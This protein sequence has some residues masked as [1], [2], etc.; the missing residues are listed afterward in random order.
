[1]QRKFHGEA[2]IRHH[3][4]QKPLFS[5]FFFLLVFCLISGLKIYND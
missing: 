5:L 1:M 3:E 4:D 2:V